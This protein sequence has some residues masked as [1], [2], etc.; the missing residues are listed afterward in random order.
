MHFSENILDIQSPIVKNSQA[1]TAKSIFQL[2]DWWVN[3]HEMEAEGSPASA[4]MEMIQDA[5]S[6]L[7]LSS[8]DSQPSISITPINCD[9]F[10]S[11]QN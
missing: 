3:K 5:P 6:E 8:L 2:F 10:L 9:S 4:L 11:K 1:I 7:E